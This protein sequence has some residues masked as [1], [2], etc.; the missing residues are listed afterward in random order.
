MKK[1][2][3]EA[4]AEAAAIKAMDQA[5]S[6]SLMIIGT[7]RGS[8]GRGDMEDVVVKIARIVDELGLGDV[9][10][11]VDDDHRGHLSEPA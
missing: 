7:M 9:D 10:E 6:L 3:D 4:G 5:L 2:K 1:E 11:K 8:G